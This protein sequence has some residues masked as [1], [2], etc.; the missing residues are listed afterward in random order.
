VIDLD[1]DESLDFKVVVAAARLVRERLGEYDLE[2]WVK[3]TGGKGL[4]V[5]V[6]IQRS[7]DVDET[8]AFTRRLCEGIER[9]VP[10]AFTTSMP[11]ARRK[12]KILLDYMRNS[13]TST[14]I[15]AYSTRKKDG[16][17]VSMPVSWEKLGS[18]RP[19]A[20]T[21]KTA[22]KKEDPWR[23]YFEAKQKP[24]RSMLR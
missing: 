10:E 1:P 24:R 18:V 15:A 13:R 14:S 12:G 6:P 9:D 2:S 11:K 22:I 4:H 3:T 5:V 7:F 17:P 16:A 20:F 23:G 8:L 19:S 21:V